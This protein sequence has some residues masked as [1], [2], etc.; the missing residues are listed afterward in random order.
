MRFTYKGIIMSELEL[1][2]IPLE[3]YITILCSL[4]PHDS[5][6]I[7]ETNTEP[8]PA[9][10]HDSDVIAEPVCFLEY[11]SDHDLDV[12]VCIGELRSAG[13]FP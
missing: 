3:Q 2:A 10:D 6:V 4:M 7:A 11:A 12:A 8:C 1:Q 13:V 5:N 9:P